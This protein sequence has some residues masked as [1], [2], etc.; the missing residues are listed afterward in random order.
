MKENKEYIANEGESDDDEGF[1]DDDSEGSDEEYK[2]NQKALNKYGAK[3][4]TGTALT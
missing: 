2:K 3:M 4:M 1:E